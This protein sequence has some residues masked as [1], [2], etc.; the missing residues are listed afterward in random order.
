VGFDELSLVEGLGSDLARIQGEEG[1]DAV[2]LQH[3]IDR[4]RAEQVPFI[5]DVTRLFQQFA[6]H[7]RERC[8]RV[9]DGPGGE[10]GPRLS[11]GMTI[12]VDQHDVAVGGQGDSV[13]PVGIFENM[14]GRARSFL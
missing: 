4:S 6:L 13:D 11:N 5:A 8:F 3:G 10:L 2:R 9:F 12:L 14:T 7:R 1:V